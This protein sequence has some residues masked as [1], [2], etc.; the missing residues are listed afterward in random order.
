M[1]YY[2]VKCTQCSTEHNIRATIAEKTENRI[3]CPE[4]GSFELE[5]MFLRP[6]ASLSGKA[7]AHIPCGER[8]GCGMRCPNAG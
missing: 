4:C 1:P 3:P 7:P 8:G 5:T 6:P 2:D